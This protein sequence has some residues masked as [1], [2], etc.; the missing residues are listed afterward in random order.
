MTAEKFKEE[1]ELR[2]L[3][4]EWG[5]QHDCGEAGC[6]VNPQGEEIPPGKPQKRS[7]TGLVRAKELW[8]KHRKG[9]LI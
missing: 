5:H 8:R 9:E 7:R 3:V 4:E 6:T 2:L 1:E